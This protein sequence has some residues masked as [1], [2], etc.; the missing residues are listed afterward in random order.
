MINPSTK[1]LSYDPLP[2]TMGLKGGGMVFV[3]KTAEA[4]FSEDTLL[5]LI[6]P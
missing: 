3:Q 6:F 5:S 2:A 1:S 4:I